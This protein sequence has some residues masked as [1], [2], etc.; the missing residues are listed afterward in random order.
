MEDRVGS[1]VFYLDRD[2]RDALRTG[3]LEPVRARQIAEAAHPGPDKLIAIAEM[4]M[5]RVERHIHLTDVPYH[6]AGRYR[7]YDP[8]V[9][10]PVE[11]TAMDASPA[12]IHR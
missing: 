5:E 8:A 10:K 3:Q 4:R 11:L 6:R 1:V 12:S 2:L 9:L 7:L